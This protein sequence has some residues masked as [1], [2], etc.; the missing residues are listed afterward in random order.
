MLERRIIDFEC[1]AKRDQEEILS[2]QK[3]VR[4]LELSLS[5]ATRDVD[6]ART[7]ANSYIDR[8]RKEFEALET[9][10]RLQYLEEREELKRNFEAMI[11]K[12]K[13]EYQCCNDTLRSASQS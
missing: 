1:R 4:D 13:E 7:S 8:T 6:E 9:K 10:N 12:V 2:L 11:R 5:L 3:N